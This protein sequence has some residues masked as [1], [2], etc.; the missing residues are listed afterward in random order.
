MN[1]VEYLESKGF[2]IVAKMGGNWLISPCPYCG[3]ESTK[4]NKHYLAT[5]EVGHCFACGEKGNLYQVMQKLGDDP[6]SLLGEKR[7]ERK[8]FRDRS[9][10]LVAVWQ[11]ERRKRPVKH[12][13]SLQPDFLDRSVSMLWKEGYAPSEQARAYLMGVRKFPE[14]ALREARIGL[15]PKTRCQ[16][17][18]CGWAGILSGKVCP[19]CGGG[20][21]AVVWWISIPYVTPDG[22][23]TLV[24]YRSIPPAEKAFA[25]EAG[26]E[27]GLYGAWKIQGPVSRLVVVEAE[28]D[29]VAC[30]ALG[31]VA[32]AISGAKNWKD[33]WLEVFENAEEIIL[34]G[35]ADEAG[36][37]AMTHVAEKVGAFRCRVLE[38]P[39]GV[40]DAAEFLERGGTPDQFSAMVD[41]A[42]PLRGRVWLSGSDFA[43]IVGRISARGPEMYGTR[44]GWRGVD[45]LLGGVRPGEVTV[46]T[47]ETGSGKS[48]FSSEWALRMAAAGVPAALA[49][50]ELGSEA[51]VTRVLSQVSKRAFY[52]MVSDRLQLQAA[53]EQVSARPFYFLDLRGTIE[54]EDLRAVLQWGVVRYGVRFI[55]LDHLHY[56]M[57]LKDPRFERQEIDRWVRTL[58]QWAE[59]W[60]AHIL[61]VVH[62]SKRGGEQHQKGRIELGDLKG[63]SG[64]SQEAHN[65]VALYRARGYE[66]AKENSGG[67]VLEGATEFAVLK[68]RSQVAREGTAWFW[69]SRESLTYRDCQPTEAQAIRELDDQTLRK[70]AIVARVKSKRAGKE[71]GPATGDGGHLRDEGGGGDEGDEPFPGIHEDFLAMY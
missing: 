59:E 11:K 3:K 15:V 69:F 51:I 39:D 9:G 35:D 55:V 4:E 41:T 2:S 5:E 57:P 54:M 43:E 23:V 42:R 44:T 45:E 6:R 14:S 52:G 10:H 20:V 71:V 68:A 12:L 40:K 47:A 64:I 62:P 30:S 67:P 1:L 22:K 32:V 27:T 21:E 24:K 8:E 61:L 53:I 28:L 65:V 38:W 19:V 31:S 46:A 33:D 37:E 49:S 50:F 26:G 36:M 48:M 60:A 18:A 56:F 16:S 70:G 29:A 17:R 34:A 66:K 7:T 25:R 13:E 58:C 63:S